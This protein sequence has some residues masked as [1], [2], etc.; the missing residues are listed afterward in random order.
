M[1]LTLLGGVSILTCEHRPA[2]ARDECLGSPSGTVRGKLR[3]LD[4]FMWKCYNFR[5][6]LGVKTRV[7]LANLGTSFRPEVAHALA[8]VRQATDLCRRVQAGMVSA[9]AMEKADRSPVTVADYGAQ[10]IMCHT[11]ASTCPDLSVVAEETA[12]ALRQPAQQKMLAQVTRL[13]GVLSPGVTSEDVCAWI[14]QGNSGPTSRFWTMDPIDGTAGFLRGEQYA[15]ALALIEGG[16]VEIGVLACPN[17]PVDLAQP[18]GS[19][20]VIFL[21]ERGKG[22]I[23]LSGDGKSDET[24]AVSSRGKTAS[25]RIVESVESNHADH[26]AHRQLADSLGIARPSLR[27][28][29]Q[30]KYGVVARGDAAIYLRLPSPDTPDYRECIWDHAAGCLLVEEAGGR[31]TDARGAGL[32]FGRGRRLSGNW[33]VV[34]S[35]G[36]LHSAL[37]GAVQSLGGS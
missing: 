4:K 16:Q 3:C 15:I 8:A 13:V 26:Q 30:A 33:G 17:L 7:N 34:V 1:Y 23:M 21:A 32:D 10:A 11:L 9:V 36:R 22:A 25:A 35:N 20:G 2:T 24:V 37:L 6:H 5:S 12:E 28:D 29:S 14:D 27:M 31:V 19:R 18:E